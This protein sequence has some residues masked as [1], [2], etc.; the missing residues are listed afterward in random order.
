MTINVHSLIHLPE[1]IKDLGPLYFYN[2][3]HLED[4]NG[5]LLKLIHGTQNIP[6]QLACAVSASNFISLL[7]EENVDTNSKEDQFIKNCHG[8]HHGKKFPI[9]IGSLSKFTPSEAESKQF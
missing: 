9:S 3:F 7:C 5:Y 4:K 2:L 8:V 1:T 6:F